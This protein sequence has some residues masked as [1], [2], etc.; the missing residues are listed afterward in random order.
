[1][2]GRARA[3]LA[4]VAVLVVSV[5][6][7]VVARA[8]SRDIE[9]QR[10]RVTQ[11]S[12]V[13]ATPCGT[14]EYASIGEGP[15]LLVVHGAGGG[16][17]QGLA[18]GRDL[19]AQGLRVIAMSRFG[20]LRTPLPADA[21][22]AAQADA[23]ACLLD[24]LD[25]DRAVVVGVSAGAPSTLQFALRHPARTRGL[26][27][28]VPAAWMPGGGGGTGTPPSTP[29]LFETALRSDWLYWAALHVAHD[30]LVGGVLATPPE[31]LRAAGADER[32][33]V[34]T[35]LREILPISQ[36][37]AGLL[38]DARVVSTLQPVPLE[39]IATPALVVSVRD[40]RFDTWPR[41]RWT[42]DHLRG[43][44]FVDVPSGGHVWVGH[45]AEIVGEVAALARRA[46]AR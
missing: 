12:A 13:V 28:V 40:D 44:R 4:G 18:F 11:G 3:A 36:R 21:S 31:L 37:R 26:G 32:R 33:R 17:D 46:A 2:T 29:W 1:M 19:A 5:L 25:I 43:A 39:R 24:A 14:I 27:L 30:A 9:A 23:H 22:A 20:Y 15:V 42:A 45:H 35:L 16:F 6:L 8:G 34:D 10:E 7:A 38:N 41:A